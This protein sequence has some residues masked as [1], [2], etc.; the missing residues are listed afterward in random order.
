[1][2][3]IDHR[4]AALTVK[5][6]VDKF[7]ALSAHLD[8]I[9]GLLVLDRAPPIK[10]ENQFARLAAAYQQS[11]AAVQEIQLEIHGRIVGECNAQVA[12]MDEAFFDLIREVSNQS[13]PGVLELPV[14]NLTRR[15][16]A[17]MESYRI[18]GVIEFRILGA[19]HWLAMVRIKVGACIAQK[20][21]LCRGGE[22]F[23]EYAGL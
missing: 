11:I 20:G 23:W 17:V 6:E 3:V 1:M 16:A 13:L 5:G 12:A 8:T 4:E 22:L 15:G 18:E 10:L 14:H 9:E 2:R 7:L 21:L 19:E